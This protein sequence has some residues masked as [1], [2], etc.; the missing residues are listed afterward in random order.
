M[1]ISSEKIMQSARSFCQLAILSIYK[2]FSE[3]NE[4]KL[5]CKVKGSNRLGDKGSVRLG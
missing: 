1:A 2:I 4:A 3:V 5:A